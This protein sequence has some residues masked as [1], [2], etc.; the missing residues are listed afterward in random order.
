MDPKLAWALRHPE[1]FPVDVQ[2]APRERLLRVPG[3]GK[4]TVTRILR[5]RRHHRLSLDDLSK[6]RARVSLASAFIVAA[7]L[8]VPRPFNTARSGDSPSVQLSLLDLA[9]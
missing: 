5:A 6:L 8:R 7:G 9:S 3:F 1:F 2:Q 4:T